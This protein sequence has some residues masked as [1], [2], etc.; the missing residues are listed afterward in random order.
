MFLNKIDEYVIVKKSFYSNKFC[1]FVRFL[2]WKI[3]N[4]KNDC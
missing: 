4:Q 1:Q 3:N 2:Q